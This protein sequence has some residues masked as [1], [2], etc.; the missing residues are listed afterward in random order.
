MSAPTA[1]LT[2]EA[3]GPTSALTAEA[4][5]LAPTAE[6]TVPTSAPMAEAT[7]PTAD[8]VTGMQVCFNKILNDLLDSFDSTRVN[9]HE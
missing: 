4:H 6:A 9:R 7:I 5:P 1:V 2:A 3:T 8:E